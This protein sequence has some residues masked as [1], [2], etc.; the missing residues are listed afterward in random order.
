MLRILAVKEDDA[1]FSGIL[2]R[3]KYDGVTPPV[4]VEIAP[5]I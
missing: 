3:D 2:V 4:P 1:K 5:E